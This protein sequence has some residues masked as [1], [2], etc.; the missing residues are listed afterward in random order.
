MCVFEITRALAI[1]FLNIF[2]AIERITKVRIFLIP[3][4]ITFLNT[5]ILGFLIIAYPGK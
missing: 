1:I 4:C 3:L 2:D 5:K